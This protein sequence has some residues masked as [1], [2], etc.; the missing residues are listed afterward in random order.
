YGGTAVDVGDMI[1]LSRDGRICRRAVGEEELVPVAE[2]DAKYLNYSR[3]KLW[4]IAENA[5]MTCGPEGKG[6]A[7]FKRFGENV[8]HLYVSDDDI[9]ILEGESVLRVGDNGEES[10]I[11]TRKGIAGFI[12]ERKSFRW[13]TENPYF[14]PELLSGEEVY[15]EIA[16]EYVTHRVDLDGND[17]A[18]ESETAVQACPDCGKAGCHAADTAQTGDNDIPEYTGPY[19]K[20]GE[21]T[22]PLARHMPGTYFTKN[23]SACTCH[24]TS[25]NYCINSVGNCNCMRYYPTGYKATCQVD[26]LGAQCFA[27]AR[28]VFWSCFGFIDNAS[29][30]SLYYNVGTL[31]RGN[32][33]KNTARE[34]L[35]KADTGAHVR[36]AAGHSV[37]ILTMDD[38]TLVIYHGN[39]GGDGVASS[40]CIVSTR[41]YTWEKFANY[42][43]PGILYVNMPRNHPGS[44]VI[45]SD[46]GSGYY[47][48]ESNVN[49]RSGAS[50][51]YDSLAVIQKGEFVL[52]TETEG[53]WGKTV[54]EGAEGWVKMS[55]LSLY[56]L[57]K[58]FPSPHSPYALDEENGYIRAKVHKQTLDSFAE[59]FSKQNIYVTDL[60][61]SPLQDGDYVG[62]GCRV[63]I[64]IG[65]AAADTADLVIAGDIN[66]N[67]Y[68]DVGDYLAVKRSVLGSYC[69]LGCFSAAADVSADGN[70]GA[71]DYLMIRRFF[72]GTVEGF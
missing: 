13:V 67:G 25:T 43:A 51:S 32:V 16:S 57:D 50:T 24:H 19:V 58:L 38:E 6:L 7:V 65:D 12:P 61:G 59:Y 22:L 1:Y 8:T 4:F 30:S 29:N 64:M 45:S 27:F 9:Y 42:A 10:L 36:T 56:S 71:E 48:A 62:T 21:V 17:I 69:M 47:V 26:L 2:F 39:A 53:D 20:V 11:F 14:D 70:V 66:G 40:P 28:M 35:Q 52:I 55:Y 33:T 68:V 60:N 18:E 37:A 44:T 31:S 54:Y 3:G 63:S 41:H 15:S 49:L 23:G 34:L 46:T 72:L 5:I